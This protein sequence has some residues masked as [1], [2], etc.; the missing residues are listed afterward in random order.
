MKKRYTILFLI[1]SISTLPVFGQVN[2]SEHIAPIIYNNCTSCHRPGEIAPMSFT[3]YSEVQAWA[4]M[5]EYVTEIRYMPP[6]KPDPNYSKF[7]GERYL[8]NQEIQLIKDWVA[9]GTPQG[10]PNL[11]PALPSF[12]TGSQVGVPDV[13]LTMAQP[14]TVQGNNTDDYRVFVLPS[15]F[16][17]DREIAAVEF[18]P[19]N[20]KAVHHA[21]IA[22]ET[23]GA[24]AAK[25][26]TTPEYGY[27]SYGDFGVDT[28]G[29]FTAYTPGIQTMK[30]TPGLGRTVPAGADILIQVHYAPLPTTEVDQSSLNIF[31]ADNPIQREVQE[32]WILPDA[33]DGGWFSFFIYPNQVRQFHASVNIP[34]DISMMSIY[35]HSHLLGRAWEVF[36]IPPQGDTIKIIKI[37]DWDFNWQG[38]YVFDKMKKIPAG[39]TL[40][41]YAAY[42]NTTNNPNNPNNPPA[43]VNWGESTTDEMFVSFFEWVPY[44]PGDENI[45]LNTG[46]INNLFTKPAHKL[47]PI[48]PNPAKGEITL[49]FSLVEGEKVTI[50]IFDVA[51]K[52]I[53]RLIDNQLYPFGQH[54]LNL[55]TAE[56]PMGTYMVNFKTERGFVATERLIVAE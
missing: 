27:F 17:Q 45:V 19:G 2:F 48:Y 28:D 12:P 8:S 56:L 15:G 16:T 49:G 20:K 46:N 42:D 25:D 13:V 50:D 26:A 37:D 9:A 52:Q 47:Y 53:K 51:G 35:P 18:R 24:A 3:N 55:Q 31:F 4:N 14:H 21:L 54:K 44:R 36:A 32:A 40:H 33:L 23:N 10:D 6:W 34:I 39:S 22:Y 29:Q 43:L 30:Y 11:E 41:F 7:I 1:S 5:I 38:N